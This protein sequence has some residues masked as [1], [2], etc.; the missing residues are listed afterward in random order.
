VVTQYEVAPAPG[1]KVNRIASLADDLALAMKAQSIRIVAPIPGK[2]AVGVEVP[3]PTARIVQLG[4]NLEG[5]PIIAD[6]AKMPHLLIA[7]ATG[8]GKSVC[9]NTIITSL[10][11]RYTPRELR[12]LMIDPKM[13][14]L[15]GYNAIPHLRHAVV[16]NNRQAAQ[17]LKWAVFE[18]EHR[19]GL[20]SANSARNIR[21]FNRRV[22][23]GEMLHPTAGGARRTR[24]QRARRTQ[25]PL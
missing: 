24:A 13:V 7:G 21:D 14:E 20:F 5:E 12:M 10:A 15:A 19:Y 22:A 3:N 18:M 23:M 4:H 16:T 17:T 2:A 9:I 1:V 6:L 11:Y 25:A 8:S